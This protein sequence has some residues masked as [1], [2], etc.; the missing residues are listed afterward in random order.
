MLVRM[1]LAKKRLVV[2]RVVVE[3]S[4]DASDPVGFFALYLS[5][6]VK[7]S[8]FEYM[9]FSGSFSKVSSQG[10]KVLC[11]SPSF[12]SIYRQFVNLSFSEKSLLFDVCS[13]PSLSMSWLLSM[14]LELVVIAV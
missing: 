12:L 13:L 8:P 10:T 3:T 2:K 11:F 4:V 6:E 14:K 5:S 7:L 1:T 9:R